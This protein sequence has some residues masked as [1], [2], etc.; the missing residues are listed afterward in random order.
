[1]NSVPRH[2][3]KTVQLHYSQTTIYIYIYILEFSN[4]QGVLLLEVTDKQ[5]ERGWNDSWVVT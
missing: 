1:M 2:C 5:R 3:Q 4:E